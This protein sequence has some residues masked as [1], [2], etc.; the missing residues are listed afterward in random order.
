MVTIF[1][2]ALALSLLS[3]LIIYIYVHKKRKSAETTE[4]IPN[5]IQ[6]RERSNIEIYHNPAYDTVGTYTT[7]NE[8]DYMTVNENDYV[9]M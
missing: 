8:N 5:T 9:K 3:V 7:V 4:E 1:T 6:I 2:T